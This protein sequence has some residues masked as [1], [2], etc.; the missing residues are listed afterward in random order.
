MAVKIMCRMD[1]NALIKRLND[2]GW[3]QTQ[4]AARVGAHQSTI[5]ELLNGVVK[6]PRHSLGAALVE[7]DESGETPPVTADTSQ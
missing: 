5:S 6:D 7:L 2:R 3:V 4:I 1:W